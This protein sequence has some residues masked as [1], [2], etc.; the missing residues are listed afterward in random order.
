MI[1]DS[2]ISWVWWITVVE[3]PLLGALFWLVHHSRR[4]ADR[5]L[6]KVYGQVQSNFSTVLQNVAQSRVEVARHYATG[7]DLKDVEKRLTNHLLR[8]E[9]RI[10]YAMAS[11]PGRVPCVLHPGANSD[12]Q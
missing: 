8:L 12:D 5:A 3:I 6:M 10:T 1:E 2:T 4:E 11:A 7:N 9:N